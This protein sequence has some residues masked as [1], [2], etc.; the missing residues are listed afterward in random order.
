MTL[1]IF[2]MGFCS[3]PRTTCLSKNRKIGKLAKY[4]LK[5]STRLLSMMISTWT[6]WI[7]HRQTC[8]LWV[9]ATQFTFG[10]RVILRWFDLSSCLPMIWWQALAQVHPQMFLELVRIQERCSCGIA[11]SKKRYWLVKGTLP[12]LVPFLGTLTTS[13]QVDLAIK[14]Y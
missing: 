5:C 9:S 6:S 14:T 1:E 10:M 4:L 12:E 8:W 3:S 7:G 2:I 13:L 11:S